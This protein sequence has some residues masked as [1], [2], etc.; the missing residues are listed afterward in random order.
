[1]IVTFEKIISLAPAVRISLPLSATDTGNG[2]GMM[3][4]AVDAN[5][6]VVN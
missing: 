6:F 4:P 5:F 2:K 3:A 1:M